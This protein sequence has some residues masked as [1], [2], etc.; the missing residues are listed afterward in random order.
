MSTIIVESN[1]CYL[2]TRQVSNGDANNHT[3]VATCVATTPD[4][5]QIEGR[6]INRKTAKYN[7]CREALKWMDN[8]RSKTVH[9]NE[10]MFSNDID[11][12]E[13]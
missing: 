10:Y 6:G 8:N 7:A 13:L 3:H 5:I 2:F 12:I 11:S 1:R 4:G 9:V